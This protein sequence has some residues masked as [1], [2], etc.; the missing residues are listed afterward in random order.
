MFT[1]QESTAVADCIIKPACHP[2]AMQMLLLLFSAGKGI[3]ALGPHCGPH[4]PAGG[5]ESSPKAAGAC[6]A[7]ARAAV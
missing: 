2:V 5:R 4:T 7:Q 1:V 6:V 3:L